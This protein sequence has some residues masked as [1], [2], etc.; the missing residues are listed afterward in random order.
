MRS[1][2]WDYQKV[3]ALLGPQM[4]KCRDRDVRIK[5]EFILLALRLNN[6]SEAC[7]RQGF[8]RK[9]FHKWWSRLLLGH[10]QLRSLEEKSRRPK[11]SPKKLA[12]TVEAR[13]RHYR[14]SRYGALMIHAFLER[15]GVQ[16]SAR[17]INHVINN[18]RRPQPKKRRRLK[19]HSRRYELVIPGQRLQVDVKY[20]PH[21]VGKE[22]A[23]TYVAIDEC[24]RWRFA[25][26][27]IAV[28]EHNTI[29]F[30]ECLKRAAPFPINCI[31]TD[32]GHEFTFK[33][34]PNVEREHDMDVW[35]S[36]NKIRHKLIPPGVKELNGKV[37]RSH[38]ID[39]DYFYWRSSNAS[40]RQFNKELMRWIDYYNTIRP[41]GGLDYITPQEK[42]AERI[43]TLPGC[44]FD[45]SLEPMRLR[46]LE[47]APRM[48]TKDDRQLLQAQKKL[49]TE[50]RKY[51]NVA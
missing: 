34:L 30:L 24:T 10:F 41:H 39:E 18:R 4:R 5:A 27:Y 3:K 51:G 50:L 46:F 32:N 36:Q 49:E 8:S 9:F 12:T 29:H 7:R 20:V 1:R 44:R 14:K 6:A 40:L 25:K 42:L 43:A 11:R 15:E 2:A 48:Q 16:V 33:M 21:L 13:I 31:Q 23:F 37:E 22:R 38:R 45:D 47:D 35:C 19:L 28:N 26:A 17:T